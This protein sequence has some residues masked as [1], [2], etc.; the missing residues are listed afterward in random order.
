MTSPSTHADTTLTPTEKPVVSPIVSPSPDYTPASPDYSLTSDMEYGISED[1]SSDR[2]PPLPATSPFLLSTDDFFKNL[3]A[4]SRALRRVMILKPG[5][6]IPHGRLYCYH[7]NRPTLSDSSSDDLSDSSFGLSSSDSSSKASSDFHSVALPDSPSRYSSSGHS[8]PDSPCDLP[9]TFAGPSRKRH[10]SPTTSILV[11]TPIH[12]ALSPARADL[13]PP[14]KRIRSSDSVMDLEVSLDESSESSV[15]RETGLR[16]DVDVEGSDEPYLEPDINTDEVETSTRGTV[17]VREDRVTH[18]MVSDDIP[19]PAQGEGAIEVTYETLRGLGSRAQDCSDESARCYDVREDQWLEWHNTRLR[20]MTM[21]NTRSRAIMT[22][23]AVD[24]LIARRVAEALEARDA[25]RNLEPLVEGGNEQEDK[26][27]DDY[28]GG[29][30]GGNGNE[31]GNGGGNKNRNGG[32]NSD[33]NRNGNCNGN[34][35]GNGYGNHNV[36]F[37]GL[38]PVA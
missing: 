10:R 7:P 24:N 29:N 5:Q 2:I 9:T 30:R 17:E 26:N 34:G 13:L 28:E 11:L 33:G 3:P 35:G 32:G 4:A 21:P 6:P 1:P 16:V 14:P 25:A 23:E 31:N 8:S 37:A 15:P 18:P 27:S 38:M 19:E 36:N 20:G 22:R 12:E